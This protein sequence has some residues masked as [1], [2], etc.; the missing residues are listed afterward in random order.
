MQSIVDVSWISW[1]DIISGSKSELEPKSRQLG[2]SSSEEQL[3]TKNTMKN[4]TEN[5]KNLCISTTI[6][7]SK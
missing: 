7:E 1:Q 2:L 4:S 5:F 3:K 6:N